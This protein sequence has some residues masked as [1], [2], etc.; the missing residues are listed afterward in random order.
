[1]WYVNYAEG[2]S[3][4][5]ELMIDVDGK[6]HRV[7]LPMGKMRP[8]ILERQRALAKRILPQ[9]SEMVRKTVEPFLQCVTD[10]LA[11]R[12]EF[13]N[14]KVLLVGDAVAGFR[15]AYPD[16]CNPSTNIYPPPKERKYVTRLP[17]T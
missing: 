1:V 6:R 10:V 11:T 5:E 15:Y 12:N 2:S 9:F 17:P 16:E 3:E 14:G 7:S 8:E 4:L 13:F